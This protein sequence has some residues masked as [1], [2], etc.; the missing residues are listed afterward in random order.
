MTLQD[1]INAY[2]LIALPGDIVIFR[3]TAFISRAI[4]DI[5]GTWASHCAVMDTINGVPN[6]IQSTINKAANGMEVYPFVQEIAG[7]EDF[8]VLRPVGFTNQQIRAAIDTLQAK[9]AEKAKYNKLFY[10]RILLWKIFKWNDA[11][12]TQ[13]NAYVCSQ[14]VQ[15]YTDALGIT[16]YKADSLIIPQDFIT[17]MPDNIKIL[18]NKGL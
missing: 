14:A 7:D 4:E 8:M 12:I 10:L 6:V 17:L 15:L 18:V 13:K 16:A 3:G 9:I 5:T 1:K 11:H 2:L